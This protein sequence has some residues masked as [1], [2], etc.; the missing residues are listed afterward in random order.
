MK[1]M[2][3]DLSPE[4]VN[5]V[6]SSPS[7]RHASLST[8][9]ASIIRRSSKPLN[10]LA[11]INGA[12]PEVIEGPGVKI[13]VEGSLEMEGKKPFFKN[14]EFNCLRVLLDEE[15]WEN[16]LV[17]SGKKNI[18]FDVA[19]AS[20]LQL[21]GNLLLAT[22]HPSRSTFGEVITNH[23]GETIPSEYAHLR[24]SPYVGMEAFLDLKA[25]QSGRI[26]DKLLLA[27]RTLRSQSALA[28]IAATDGL[29]GSFDIP[30]P[31]AKA[32]DGA[33]FRNRS[34]SFESSGVR[35]PDPEKCSWES[36]RCGEWFKP[37]VWELTPDPKDVVALSERGWRVLAVSRA[38]SKFRRLG[39]NS[40]V[41]VTIFQG[42]IS[43]AFGNG[44]LEGWERP[45]VVRSGSVGEIVKLVA[46]GIRPSYVA[47]KGPFK[48]DPVSRLR[49]IGYKGFSIVD[50]GQNA[51]GGPLAEGLDY[52]PEISFELLTGSQE[53]HASRDCNG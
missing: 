47:L 24:D 21:Q 46:A 11:Y 29:I 50:R 37:V 42:R 6:I 22:S 3:S 14:D 53:L 26:W 1:I 45:H 4:R 32:A 48:K 36:L 8:V 7:S 19:E 52:S 35:S 34:G 43:S 5:I 51:D 25:M 2:R 15:K 23:R 27:S 12:T 38:T 41:D 16:C 9:I 18:R 17:L 10:I 33:N 20:N 44:S 30:R 28:L 31:P 40:D 13:R 49:S 39:I